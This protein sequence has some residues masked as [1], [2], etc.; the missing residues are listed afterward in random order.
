MPSAI[1]FVIAGLTQGVFAM[2]TQQRRLLSL[3]FLVLFF[4]GCT[5]RYPL[6]LKRMFTPSQKTKVP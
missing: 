1:L 6:G 2:S 3:L 5:T 4:E